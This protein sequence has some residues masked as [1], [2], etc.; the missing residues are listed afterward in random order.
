M[1]LAFAQFLFCPAWGSREKGRR[2]GEQGFCL[3]ENNTGVNK[4]PDFTNYR[5]KVFEKHLVCLS[6]DDS[7]LIQ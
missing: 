6:S 4:S 1:A 5:Y 3:G 7:D 2:L